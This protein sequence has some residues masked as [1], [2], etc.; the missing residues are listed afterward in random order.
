MAPLGGKIDVA[1]RVGRTGRAVESEL[2]GGRKGLFLEAPDDRL[3]L[4]EIGE[5]AVDGSELDRAHGVDSGEPALGEIAHVT[6]GHLA[7]PA[8]LAGH[9]VGDLI[10][11]LV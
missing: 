7:A 10:E 8:H 1:A 9:P 4:V 2:I 6:G 5:I 3:E 11:L